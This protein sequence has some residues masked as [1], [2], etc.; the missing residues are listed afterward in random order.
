MIPAWQGPTEELMGGK[1]NFF[2]LHAGP[3]GLTLSFLT[4]GYQWLGSLES[5]TVSGA[6]LT[7]N[8]ASRWSPLL[9][10]TGRRANLKPSTVRKRLEGREVDVLVAQP[11]WPEAETKKGKP[12][13]AVYLPPP[14]DWLGDP[15]NAPFSKIL[16]FVETLRPRIVLLN[17][18][19]KVS[20]R[21]DL[22]LLALHCRALRKRGY[23]VSPAQFLDSWFGSPRDRSRVVILAVRGM[24]S[25]RLALFWP[26]DR[27]FSSRDPEPS[28]VR[29]SVKV[30]SL[31]D[32]WWPLA[33]PPRKGL[34]PCPGLEEVFEDLPPAALPWPGG[35]A[36]LD[37]E[38]PY[39]RRPFGWYAWTLRTWVKYSRRLTMHISIPADWMGARKAPTLHIGW[40]ADILWRKACI[41]ARAKGE[42]PPPRELK[43]PLPRD[44]PGLEEFSRDPFPRVP[45]PDPPLPGTSPI[46]WQDRFLRIFTEGGV[47]RTFSLREEARMATFPDSWSFAGGFVDRHRQITESFPPLPGLVLARTVAHILEDRAPVE[48][49]LPECP[50]APPPRPPEERLASKESR[51]LTGEL[52]FAWD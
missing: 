51:P 18:I 50:L 48:S 1:R 52:P 15:R 11:R 22:A 24:D 21:Q 29:T 37:E 6:T 35:P 7:L 36:P 47:E 45:L 4:A 39:A 30:S 9:L 44:F 41:Q 27:L 23:T 33:P 2:E 19:P 13:K 5:S 8:A 12:R 34:P 46:L 26:P 10:A 25:R 14:E 38:T 28:W 3:G 32:A 43:V 20:N 16:P 40:L 42:D 49:L 31:L 17:H